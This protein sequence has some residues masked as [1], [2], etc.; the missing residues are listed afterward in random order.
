MRVADEDLHRIHGTN[1]RIS[2]DNYLDVIRFFIQ[3]IRN[4]AS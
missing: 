1:E 4:S 2:V 3:Q